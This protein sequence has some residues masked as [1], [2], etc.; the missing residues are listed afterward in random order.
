MAAGKFHNVALSA[1]GHVYTWGV[2]S[3]QLGHGP[4]GKTCLSTP[5]LVEAMLPE[6]GGGRAVFVS[7]SS[8]R[9]CV[10]SDKGDL[11]TWG[12]TDDSVSASFASQ[13][14]R[15]FIAKK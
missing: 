7:A 4:L 15:G 1:A 3:D 12:A 11:Y 8:N 13:N 14:F 6:R 5:T 9:T 2:G 10:T